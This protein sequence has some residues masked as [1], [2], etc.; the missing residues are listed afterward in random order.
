MISENCLSTAFKIGDLGLEMCSYS[1]MFLTEVFVLKC[2]LY[3]TSQL[4]LIL[5]IFFA[6]KISDYYFAAYIKMHSRLL[7]PWQQI[8]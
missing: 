1:L 3:V 7:L 4:N 2:G 5:L 8:L 6:L